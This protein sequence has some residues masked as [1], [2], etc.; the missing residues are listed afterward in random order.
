MSTIRDISLAPE[1]EKKIAWVER[2]MPLL[3]SIAAD[4]ERDRPFAGLKV[5]LSVHLEGEYDE[6]GICVGTPCVIGGHGVEHV[7]EVELSPRE[8]ELMRSSCSIIRARIEEV[9]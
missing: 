4:M 7:L 8:R 6:R 5:A 1:G 3:R 2:N 9:C